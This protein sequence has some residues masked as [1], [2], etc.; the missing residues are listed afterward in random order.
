MQQLALAYTTFRISS[1]YSISKV[2]HKL[3]MVQREYF[4]RSKARRHIALAENYFDLAGKTSTLV[5]FYYKYLGNY[6]L[7][8]VGDYYCALP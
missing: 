4:T 5:G 3:K 7:Q 6:F 2:E 8:V 1:H